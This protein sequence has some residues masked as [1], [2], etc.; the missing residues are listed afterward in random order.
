MKE[1]ENLNFIEKII[2]TD[3]EN[4]VKII[5]RFP[6][7]PNGFLHLGHVKSIVLNFSMAQKYKGKCNLRFDDTNPEK[8]S[9]VYI[10]SIQEDV[11]WLGFDYGKVLFASDYYDEMY[12]TA[13]K[14]IKEGKA[15]VDSLTPEEIKQT[16]GTLTQKGTESPNRNKSVDENLKEFEMMKE[17][18]FKESERVLRAKIDMS[19]PNIN[20]RD[21]VIYR[22]RYAE[23]PRTGNKWCIYPMYDLAHS[24]E[25]G[26]EGITH[27][28]CTLEFE[29]HRPLYDWVV[30]NDTV[31]HKP[32]QIEFSRLNVNYTIMSKRKLLYLV[33]NG[34]VDGWDDPRLPTIAGLRRRGYTPQSLINFVSRVGIGKVEGC[35]DYSLLEFSLREELNKKANRLFAIFDPVK[36]VI[37]NYPDDKQEMISVENNPEDEG[38]GKRNLIF[39]KEIY[40]ERSDFEEDPPKGFFRLTLGKE[41]RLK[42]GY[43]IKAVSVEKDENSKIKLI[44]AVYD[45]LTKGG[46]SPDGRPVKGTIHWLSVKSAY[47]AEARLYDKL[48]LAENPGERTG[49]YLDDVNPESLIVQN[50]LVEKAA[51]ELKKNEAVQFVRNGYFVLD[52]KQ[53]GKVPVFNRCVT[54]KDSWAKQNKKK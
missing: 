21:P 8:E 50:I 53:N 32:R 25:D 40:I 48:F 43:Y 24:I 9:D 22:I 20:M 5:T 31:A 26:I 44:H 1:N 39:S 19:S 49:N 7:E 51:L 37:D 30:D 6:P 52:N 14:L 34:Y 38:A 47:D 27:S 23:H 11:S 28:L 36:V 3:H 29:D 10:K 17:G 4:G 42:G 15:Y 54:L 18:K 35:I 45:P 46:S 16:R 2:K 33:E 12:K 13:I 41:V